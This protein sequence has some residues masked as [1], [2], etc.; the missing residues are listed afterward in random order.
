MIVQTH[1][2]FGRIQGLGHLGADDTIPNL[3]G[4]EQLAW[5]KSVVTPTFCDQ[6]ACGAVTQNEAGLAKVFACGLAYPRSPQAPCSTFCQPWWPQLN[7]K[8]G[9]NCGITGQVFQS[10]VLSTPQSGQAPAPAGNTQYSVPAP[11]YYDNAPVHAPSSVPM[12]SR[13]G[14]SPDP[15]P[16]ASPTGPTQGP[17]H[18]SNNDNTPVPSPA[19][20]TQGPTTVSV[21]LPELDP[22]TGLLRCPAQYPFQ[23]LENG[24]V[25][26]RKT[27]ESGVPDATAGD[28]GGVAVDSEGNPMVVYLQGLCESERLVEGVSDCIVLAAAGI[29]LYL[30]TRDKKRGR[31]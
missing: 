6:L 26:C 5:A 25:V 11:A 13:P 24:Q 4:P 18:Y 20:A 16:V 10:A 7:A 15:A 19:G 29:G 3:F 23:S 31:R 30:A 8:Y 2:L 17:T 28:G 12:E 22:N 1:G 27:R 9:Y 14:P 21:R